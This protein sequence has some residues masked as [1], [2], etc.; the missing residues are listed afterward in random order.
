LSYLIGF[1]N[2]RVLNAVGNPI[3]KSQDYKPYCL[4]HLKN[5]K[6][7]DYRLFVDEAVL[8][9][10][11]QFKESLADLAIKEQAAKDAKDIIDRKDELEATYK[12]SSRFNYRKRIF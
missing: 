2:L 7:L 10:K 12:V 3:A 8:T 9:A 1:E 11:E 5:L 6:Y 4:A